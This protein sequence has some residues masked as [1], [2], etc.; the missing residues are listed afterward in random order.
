MKALTDQR[1]LSIKNHLIEQAQIAAEKI[2]VEQAQAAEN[3]QSMI[4]VGVNR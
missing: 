2:F 1:S 4:K 3:N